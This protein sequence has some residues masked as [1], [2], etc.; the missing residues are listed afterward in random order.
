[1]RAVAGLVLLTVLFGVADAA[2]KKRTGTFAAY[3]DP[4]A[5]DDPPQPWSTF[6]TWL[7]VVIVI[8]RSAT[9]AGPK[10]EAA[11]AAAQKV[12]DCLLDGD[13]VAIVAVDL[14]VR[15]ALRA[16]YAE[17]RTAFKQVLNGVR[18]T[19]EGADLAAA[20]DEARAYLEPAP[21][22]KVI[23]LFTDLEQADERLAPALATARR[24]D[25][26][27]KLVAM[28]GSD[29]M[30]LWSVTSKADVGSASLDDKSY[31]R[32]NPAGIERLHY[33]R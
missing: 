13:Q 22:R 9:T 6:P 10:L 30:K 23:V 7:S 16:I 14:S 3:I 5:P 8:D 21:E 29:E 12:G 17:N 20:I 24:A 19:D 4:A 32:F 28:P 33:E 18:P 26:R 15:Y 1:M 11:K 2:P 31:W 25:I 27:V